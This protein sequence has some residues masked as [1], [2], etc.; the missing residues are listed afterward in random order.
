[1]PSISRTL[2][3]R[4]TA[5]IALEED[6]TYQTEETLNPHGLEEQSKGQLTSQNDVTLVSFTKMPKEAWGDS[7]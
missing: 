3:N 6:E 5:N 2:E 1:M 4:G 7:L